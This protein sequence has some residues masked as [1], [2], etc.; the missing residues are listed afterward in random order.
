MVSC[1]IFKFNNRWKIDTDNLTVNMEPMKIYHKI[2]SP[3]HLR[4]FITPL[5]FY[6][7][8]IFKKLYKAIDG[9]ILMTA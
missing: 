5:I 9:I 8:S 3:H 1:N 2:C 6:R 4:N 7:F